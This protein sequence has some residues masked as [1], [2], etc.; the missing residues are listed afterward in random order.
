MSESPALDTSLSLRYPIG[1]FKPSFAGGREAIR[2]IAELP[3][4]LWSAVAG[5]SDSQLDTAYREDGWT[6]RQLVH[7]VADS[8]INAS[9]RF[10]LA[11]TED[12][13]TIKPYAEA[14]W[15][16][17]ADARTQRV[18]VSLELLDSLHRRWVV[19]L[20]SLSAAEWARGYVHP[21][22]GRQTLDTVA[23]LYAWH[24]RHHTAHV[25]GLRTR[26]GWG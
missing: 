17:L 25:T 19:L 5:L 2:A 26:L 16:E 1:K 24:G 18:E 15:A 9:V 11:L 8:H 13:P 12:F 22:M 7:H 10:R 20:E 14:R 3:S 6:V 21:E 4:A 23:A